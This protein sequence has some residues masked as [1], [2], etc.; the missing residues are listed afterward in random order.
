MRIVARVRLSTDSC[1]AVGEAMDGRFSS[2]IADSSGPVWWQRRDG[3]D[4]VFDPV[5]RPASGG[6]GLNDIPEG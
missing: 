6:A 1:N 3:E 5:K 2:T 4:Q